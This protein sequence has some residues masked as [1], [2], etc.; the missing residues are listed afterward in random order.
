MTIVQQRSLPIWPLPLSPE[1]RAKLVAAK[2]KLGV[3][4]LVVP[5]PAFSKD[6]DGWFRMTDARVLCLREDPPVLCEHA[7]VK[8]LDNQDSL[9]AALDYVLSDRV[10]SRATTVSQMLEKLIPGAREM[11][12]DEVKYENISRNMRLDDGRKVPMFR[13]EEAR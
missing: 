2:S 11:T 1:D 3:D 5:V 13:D 8:N 12:I 10:D 4:F 6:S 7:K 9:I